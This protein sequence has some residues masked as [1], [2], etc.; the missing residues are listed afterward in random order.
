MRRLVALFGL[1]LVATPPAL[2]GGRTATKPIQTPTKPAAKLPDIPPIFVEK[3]FVTPKSLDAFR[4]YAGKVS[5]E[6]GKNIQITE[7]FYRAAPLITYWGYEFEPNALGTYDVIFTQKFD[8]S[9]LFATLLGAVGGLRD[10]GCSNWHVTNVRVTAMAAKQIDVSGG[11]EGTEMSCWWF[12]GEQKT[13]IGDIGGSA[14]GRLSFRVDTSGDPSAR[15]KGSFLANDPILSGEAKATTILGINT[16]SVL[17][18]LVTAIGHLALA[19]VAFVK[20]AFGTS[21]WESINFFN[22][23]LWRSPSIAINDVVFAISNRGVIE[24]A[25]YRK[26]VG[27]ITEITWSIQ[28]NFV[29]SDARSGL[30][31]SPQAPILEV[32]FVTTVKPK[33]PMDTIVADISAEISLIKS[34]SQDPQTI[35]AQ[36]GQNFWKLSNQIYGTP[37]YYSMLAAANGLSRAQSYRVRAGAK[38]K[39]PPIYQLPLMPPI[40]FMKPGET[41]YALCK[42]RFSTPVGRCMSAIAQA[43][44]RLPLSDL[45]ALEAIQL[46][47]LPRR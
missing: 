9:S 23:S 21:M 4:D 47:K 16:A 19:P 30:T 40:H 12:F 20:D 5:L 46:P 15:Y 42:E 45:K 41:I 32:S 28:P 25:K 24:S 34:F 3:P 37:Y 38:V 27:E 29:I 26:F 36:P 31:G 2:A 6:T 13:K 17:G 11:I 35:V 7:D 44:P 22:G 1:I 18:Q 14:T 33:F 8:V 10:D 43:N 39:A